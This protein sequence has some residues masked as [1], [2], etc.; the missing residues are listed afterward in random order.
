MVPETFRRGN[1]KIDLFWVLISLLTF[2]FRY[3]KMDYLFLS[4][5]LGLLALQL[6][7]LLYNIACQWS[8]NFSRRLE[9]MP[10]NLR[11]SMPL[12]LFKVPKFHLPA[13]CSDCHSIFSF[14]F[15]PGIGRTDREDVECNWLWLNG[16][17][18]ST[19]QIGPG[20]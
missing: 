8:R 18:A 11:T 1:S 13:H 4:S 2:L 10:A 5:I 7:I 12:I 14:N 3:C 17:A 6:L 9:A 20:S 15:M 19:S 16:T